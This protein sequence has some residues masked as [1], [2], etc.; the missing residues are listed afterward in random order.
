MSK[1]FYDHL[2]VL[3]EVELELDKLDLDRGERDELEHLIDE[4]VHHRVLDRILI[5]LPRHHHADFLDRFH[6]A[7]HDQYLLQWLDERI[8]E[9][10]EDHIKTV[11]D[12]IKNELVKLKEE[13]L[14]D[15]REDYVLRPK[16]NSTRKR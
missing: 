12:H 14:Q 5:Q 2:I 1:V 8:E 9:S 13:I 10:V 7:P 6:R 16:K 15:I 11:E 3:E 4:L